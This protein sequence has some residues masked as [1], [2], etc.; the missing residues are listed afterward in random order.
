MNI[1]EVI[2]TKVNV[3]DWQVS[4]TVSLLKEGA[5]IPFISRYRKERT[6]GL[7][8]VKLQEIK[9]ELARIEELEKRKK[10]ILKAIK[11]QDQLTSELESKINAT[12]DVHVL[13]DIYLPYKQKRKTKAS[14]ARGY[15]LEPMAKILMSQRSDDVQEQAKRFTSPNAQTIEE[16]LE[17]ARYIMAEWMSE[18]GALR[19]KLR[20]HFQRNAMITS[21]VVKAKEEEGEKFRD[22]FNHT[23][24]AFKCRSHR[25]LAIRRGEELGILKV[26]ILPPEEET[27]DMVQDFFKKGNTASSEQVDMAAKDAYKR[28]I[29]PSLE[30][31]IRNSLKEKA[32]LEAIKVFA[33]NLRQLLLGA[34]LGQKRILAIDPGF[35]TGCKL[36][37]LDEQGELLHNENIYPHPPKN[38][39]SKAMSK[40]SNLVDTYKIEAIAI[41]N[42]TAS[43]ETENFITRIKF[44]RTLQVFVVSED[45]A[46]VYSASKVA[47][48]EF[49]Q[50]DV[51]VRGAISIGRRLMDPLSELVKIEP[52]SIGVGQYQH[53]VDQKLLK[54]SLDAVV[55][56]CVNAVGVNVNTAS[57][58][59]LTYV[60]G[61][62]PV[63]AENIVKY[64][65][66]NG[67]FINREDLLSVS[68]MGDKV[69]EQCAGFLR[70]PDGNDPLDNSAVHPERY[71][72]VE[73]MS[74]ELQLS[75][76][77]L[78][79]NE[80]ALANIQM[81]E[82]ITDEVGLPTI[83]DIVGELQKPGRDPRKKAKVFAFEKG[84][85]K[86]EDLSAGMRLPGI[87]TNITNFGCFVDVG[88]KQ[89]G[90]IHIS[91][92][93]DRFISDPNEIVSL[94]EH[95]MVEVLEVDKERKRIGFRLIEG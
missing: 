34:P 24:L 30:T 50:Y 56:S 84:I 91:N 13:E 43:R 64:R 46:S 55:E 83:Q 51:T 23:E 59:L 71:E 95:V 66:E 68:R 45:G 3:K 87:V 11:S 63:L 73:E 85:S 22:Y 32:D 86:I 21:K 54:E 88:V 78:I 27:V 74:K 76:E 81:Q 47:R 42:G 36:V 52:R 4:N 39:R 5:T 40:V 20:K 26:S 14:I 61:V 1:Q 10:T 48:E 93:A 38:E 17:G 69:Y 58:Y 37:C 44:N 72:L 49:P 90:L 8:E 35:R 19:S 16:V 7:D 89:D 70:I 80:K 67:P 82:Y 92:M 65:S 75:V 15:G 62:G 57:K 77:Q 53:D 33:R 9:T 18:N 41:G 60:S 25:M 31:E 79:G 94:H 28:L 2:A 6:G 12:T 29:R